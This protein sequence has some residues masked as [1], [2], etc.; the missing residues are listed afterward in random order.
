[1]SDILKKR[2]SKD[3]RDV[4]ISR[5]APLYIQ[6]KNYREI[7]EILGL[8]IKQVAVDITSIKEDWRKTY[9]E[10][11]NEY[12]KRELLKIDLLEAEAWEA[13]EKSKKG[14]TS[15]VK[16]AE[17]SQQFGSR[18][19]ATEEHSES[20]GDV[21][22]LQIVHTCVNTRARLLG[23]YGAAPI[24]NS[25]SESV[26]SDANKFSRDEVLTLIDS[27]AGRVVGAVTQAPQ[28]LLE[29][30]QEQKAKNDA[31][32]VPFTEVTD[33]TEPRQLPPSVDPIPSE[34]PTDTPEVEKASEIL[35]PES[36]EEQKASES[37][38]PESPEE[39]KARLLEILKTRKAEKLPD[40]NYKIPRTRKDDV[41]SILR[42][43]DTTKVAR[44]IYNERLDELDQ[45]NLTYS[46]TN[47]AISGR[48]KVTK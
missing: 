35:E 21:Q 41:R 15:K 28:N 5:I 19:S 31:I 1:M 34:T 45:S 39:E 6:G 46:E 16:T 2:R 9:I 11:F 23:M 40:P 17:D 29:A 12:R 26:E 37:L 13:W 8:S 7:A 36:P 4:D 44:E 3:Q 14:R 48:N 25:E 42:D 32:D 10:D 27:I 18:R 38:E 24:N 33:S 20:H 30:M 47:K 22:Y 43:L